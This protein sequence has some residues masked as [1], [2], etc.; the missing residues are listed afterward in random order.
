MVFLF[1]EPGLSIVEI[2]CKFTIA[3][4]ACEDNLF[5]AN[6][7]QFI[8]LFAAPVECMLL[9][10]IINQDRS[11]TSTNIVLVLRDGIVLGIL[12]IL[13]VRIEALSGFQ[14]CE[15]VPSLY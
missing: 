10:N 2:D 14:R 11:L 7:A 5:D 12:I 4:V 1:F 15:E 3:F 13:K 9:G 8:R 6:R